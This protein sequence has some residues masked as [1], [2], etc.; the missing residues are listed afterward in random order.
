[1]KNINNH[2]GLSP[3]QYSINQFLTRCWE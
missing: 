2:A 1:L 3:G